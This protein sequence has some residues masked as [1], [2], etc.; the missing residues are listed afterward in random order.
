MFHQKKEQLSFVF[1]DAEEMVPASLIQKQLPASSLC[2][3][4]F[5]LKAVHSVG[6][7][8]HAKPVPQASGVTRN[9]AG[10]LY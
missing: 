5:C 7:P 2:C 6:I 9:M 1:K 8:S 3:F 4:S 10:T